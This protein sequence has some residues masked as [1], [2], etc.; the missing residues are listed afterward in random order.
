MPIWKPESSEE[1]PITIPTSWYVMEARYANG[2]I[3]N[4][5]VCYCGEGRVS[6]NI[7]NFDKETR[8]A[9]TRSGRKYVLYPNNEGYNTD[10]S[11]VW[12]WVRQRDGIVD[13]EIT[14]DYDLIK[15]EVE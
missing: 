11:Y 8:V 3:E 14:A 1:E 4:R 12:D 2:N 6:S 13:S 5:I 7:I 9:T 10:A 15:E